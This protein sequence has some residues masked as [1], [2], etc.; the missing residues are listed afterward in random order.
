MTLL[1]TYEKILLEANISNS[2]IINA[3]KNRLSVKFYYDGD[4]NNQK[5][6]II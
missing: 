6:Y 4:K 3:I 5:G 2:K 1:E